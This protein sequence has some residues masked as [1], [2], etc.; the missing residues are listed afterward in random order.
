MVSTPVEWYGLKPK[1]EAIIEFEELW[2]GEFVKNLTKALEKHLRNE[3]VETRN[4]LHRYWLIGAGPDDIGSPGNT[5]DY[6]RQKD[7]QR[8][9]DLIRSFYEDTETED[10]DDHADGHGK[11]TGNTSYKNTPV[12]HSLE[13]KEKEERDK[14][15]RADCQS[16]TLRASVTPQ[17]PLLPRAA[18][19]RVPNAGSKVFDSPFSNHCELQPPPQSMSRKRRLSDPPEE[20]QSDHPGSTVKMRRL[21]D[22]M[23]R[24]PVAK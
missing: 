12:R 23:L 6:Y 11:S 13:Q 4:R 15:K 14:D 21:S 8:Q 17:T 1:T 9:E 20:N 22:P 2:D 16:A 5:P 3:A 18:S 24:K 10:E 7:R 19:D